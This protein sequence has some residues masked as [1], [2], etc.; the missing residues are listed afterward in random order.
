MSQARWYLLAT[1][2]FSLLPAY[3][4]KYEIIPLVGARFGGTIQLEQA[5]TPNVNAHLADSV[6]F[7]LAGGVRFDGSEGE[8]HDVIAFR[9]MRQNTHLALKQ[10]PLAPPP[11]FRPSVAVDHFLGDFTHEF[12]VKDAPAVQ[13]FIT[14]TVGAARMSAPASSATRFA[15]GMG[16]GVKIFPKTH[17]GFLVKAE[18]LPTVMHAGLQ[19]VVCAGGCV[20]ALDGGIMNQFEVSLGPA[21]RF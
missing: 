1:L 16:G 12:A 7:G 19:K 20:V 18:Y 11:T 17:W 5:G 3:G 8:G 13:P 9:W 15:F 21:F 2:L 6:S 14:A 10:D 4:Q